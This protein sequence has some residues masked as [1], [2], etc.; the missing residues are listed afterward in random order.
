MKHLKLAVFLLLIGLVSTACR[1]E[2]DPVPPMAKEIFP[3]ED[4]K[5]RIYHVIDTS[6]ASAT[7]ED[8]RSYY[9]RELTDGTET[10]LLDREVSTLWLHTSTDTLGTPD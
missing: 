6:Y 4:G 2:Y 7:L 3:I 8:A 1:R 5:Y 9:K 10:D